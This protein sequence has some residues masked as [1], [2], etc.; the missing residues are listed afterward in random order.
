MITVTNTLEGSTSGENLIMIHKVD[1]MSSA[2]IPAEAV[3]NNQGHLVANKVA[4]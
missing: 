3:E 1:Y 2:L 4:R